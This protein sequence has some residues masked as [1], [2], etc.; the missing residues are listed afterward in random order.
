MKQF[1]T[2]LF[3]SLLLLGNKA[4]SQI[5]LQGKV[6]SA[7]DQT[8]IV[9]A[10]IGTTQNNTLSNLQ[11]NFEL[12]IP[13]DKGKITISAVGFLSQEI[14]IN[15]HTTLTILLTPRAEL[16]SLDDNLIKARK[17]N[18]L[19]S[20]GY[21]TLNKSELIS[22]IA[23]VSDEEMGDQAV[24]N[25]AQAFQGR[26]AG[27]WVL[28]NSGAPGGGISIKIR[29]ITSLGSNSEPLYVLDGIPL[30]IYN[31]YSFMG[32]IGG[33]T[34]GHNLY[35]AINPQDIASIDVLKDAAAATIYGSRGS[36]GIIMITTKRGKAQKTSIQYKGFYGVQEISKRIPFLNAT[37]YQEIMTEYYKNINV[38]IPNGIFDNYDTNW[39]DYVYRQAPIQSH[40]VSVRG[41][42]DKTRF[43][44]SLGY[45]QQIGIIQNSGISRYSFRVNLD[46]QLTNRLR[47]GTSLV[48]SST[49]QSLVPEDA[50]TG[51][52]STSNVFYTRP[53]LPVFNPDGTYYETTALENPIKI[54]MERKIENQ[55]LYI[56]NHSFVEAEITNGLLWKTAFSFSLIN[57]TENYYRPITATAI[58]Q[59]LNGQGI[60]RFLKDYM[61]NVDNTLAYQKIIE[62]G[63]NK[64]SLNFLAGFGLQATNR[65]RMSATASNFGVSGITTLGA[66]STLQNISTSMDGWNLI[67]YFSRLNYVLND[68]YYASLNFRVDGSSRFAENKKYG[69]FPSVA[70]AWR[71]SKE[72]FMRS[73]FW[74]NDLKLRGS[75]GNTGNQE[76]GNYSSLGLYTGGASYLS[77]PSFLPSS[78]ANP[79]LTWE[80]TQQV[81]VGFDVSLF[82]DRISLSMDWYLKRT[83]DLLTT[84]QLPTQSGFASYLIN[85][86][87]LENMGHEWTLETQNIVNKKITWTSSFN[88]AFNRNLV[89]EFPN[90][91]T[92]SPNN[93]M[94]VQQGA[95]LNTLRGWDMI[96]VDP[97]TGSILFRDRNGNPT[98][99]TNNADIVLHG[100]TIPDFIG[101][102]TNQMN[103]KGFELSIYAQFTY[104]NYI[105]NRFRTFTE[106]GLPAPTNFL[107]SV[108]NRWQKD[109][110]ITSIPRLSTSNQGGFGDGRVSQRWFENASFL[111]LQNIS[112]AYR[113]PERFLKKYSLS[114]LKLYISVQNAFVFTKYSGYDPEVNS[115]AT[116]LSSIDA[117]AS[118]GILNGNAAIGVDTGAYPR[119]RT[120]LGGIHIEF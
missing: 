94:I 78:L 88:I 113:I 105:Y 5:K 104:G 65:E 42:N 40:D 52:T 84:I 32:A 91:I 15:Q 68:R 4:F 39:A 22:S 97:K 20:I 81:D 112:L 87:S 101:G 120:F 111:R 24:I 74:I 44:A 29:G 75:F 9:G 17:K 103:Y 70:V 6:L 35:N 93:G 85:A 34:Q 99:A 19:I 95:S 118:G 106:A 82:N 26:L 3:I 71:I 18:Q 38:P 90:A 89:V 119:A 41:G 117:A 49:P 14:Q 51:N 100:K 115:I 80:T 66:A 27:V 8:P 61:W 31:N 86:G 58:G 62:T 72:N 55:H 92:L 23:S 48:V 46:Q 108:I 37:Q 1:F 73:L 43:Y 79:N 2:C 54:L 110:D 50:S 109:G 56:G 98:T 28:P 76:I 30:N 53:T 96:G 33:G 36:N 107:A 13:D 47:I 83:K 10:W 25:A 60:S 12:E 63:I 116:N 7:Q 16:L 69:I 77:Q 67:S 59:Q 57:F 11:G 45:F 21:G 102:F 114:N 64:H